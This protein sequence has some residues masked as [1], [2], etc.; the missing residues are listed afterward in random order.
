MLQELVKKHI[1]KSIKKG[2][3]RMK[4]MDYNNIIE[5]D[6]VTLQDCEDMYRTKN[7]NTIINDGRIINFEKENNND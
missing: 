1:M 7:M 3:R 5:L 6:N 2:I 4:N